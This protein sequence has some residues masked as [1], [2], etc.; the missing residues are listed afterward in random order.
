MREIRELEGYIYAGECVVDDVQWSASAG[1][2]LKI[3]LEHPADY[4]AFGEVTKRR[5]KKAGQILLLCI[6]VGDDESFQQI[7]GWFAGW[8]VTH[9]KGAVIALT[10]DD[11]TF[12]QLRVLDEKQKIYLLVYEVDDDEEVVNEAK[13]CDIERKLKGGPM[14]VQ[15]GRACSDPGFRNWLQSFTGETI[16]TPDRAAEVIRTYC[17]VSTRALLDHDKEARVRWKALYREWLATTL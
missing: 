4:K 17:G 6:R 1:G 8:S 13:R 9:T 2:K 11:D 5:G 10:I 12:D 16:D 15:S 3:L 14:S 7:E